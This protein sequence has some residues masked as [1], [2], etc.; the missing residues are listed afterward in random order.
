MLK[1]LAVDTYL[2]TAGSVSF[3]EPVPKYIPELAAY[4]SKNA[5][6]LWTNDIDVCDY[7][8]ITAAH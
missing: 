1:L 3:N 6:A 2:A 4:A 8:D 7:S 5:A